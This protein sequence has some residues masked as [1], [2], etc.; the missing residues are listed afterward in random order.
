MPDAEASCKRQM[1]VA[2]FASHY[3]VRTARNRASRRILKLKPD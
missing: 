3:N 2:A 1:S